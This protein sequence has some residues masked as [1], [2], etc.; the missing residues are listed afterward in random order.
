ME[1]LL[2]FPVPSE[3]VPGRGISSLPWYGICQCNDFELLSPSC[4]L[5]LNQ[6]I[7]LTLFQALKKMMQTDFKK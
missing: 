5:S 6:L 1:K 7:S 3:N 2:S 4:E